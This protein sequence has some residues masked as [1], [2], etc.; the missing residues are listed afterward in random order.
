MRDRLRTSPELLPEWFLRTQSILGASST[1]ESLGSRTGG[2]DPNRSGRSL[3]PDEPDG[4]RSGINGLNRPLCAAGDTHGHN[5]FRHS[6]A[7]SSPDGPGFGQ[8]E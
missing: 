2:V 5:C 6:P 4:L 7:D 1:F 3:R 8:T